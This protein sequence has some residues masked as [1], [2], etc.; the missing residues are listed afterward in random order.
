[1]NDLIL[2]MKNITKDFPG[3]R[4]LDDVSI[5]L[6]RSEVL[7]LLGE[8]GAG[9]S[10]LIKILSGVVSL[11]K[12]EILLNGNPVIFSNPG[13]S[14][15]QGIRV[16]Y[17]ELS[18]FES[19]TVVENIFAGEQI[20]KK[21]GFI[22]WNQMVKDANQVL[23]N[24]DSNID[25][26]EIMENLSVAAKQIVEIAKAVHKKAKIIVMDEPTSALNDKDVQTL[27]SIIKQLKRDGISIIYI[28]HRLEEIFAITDRVE[29]LRDGKNVGGGLINQIA[30]EDILK[31]IV[32]K[33]F[34]E[35]YPK[36]YVPKGD[37]I[38]EVNNISYINKLN[39]ISFKLR[40]GEIVA[41]FGLLG[42]GK[43]ELLNV[44]FGDLKKSSGDIIVNGKNVDINHPSIAKKN[45][46]GLVPIDRKDEGIALSLDVKS[47][48]VISNI[49][50]IGKGLRLSRAMR[51]KHAL[52]WIDR[53]NIKTPNDSAIVNTL[54][55]GNQQKIVL[56][57]WLEKG[58]NIL[59]LVE[60]TRG[61][62]IGSKAEIY[63]ILEDLCEQGAGVLMVS[64]ELPEVMAISDR[65]MV[66]KDGYIVN[67][68]QTSETSPAELMQIVT[69]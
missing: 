15:A 38:L 4:A 24:L 2:D 45:N 57:K 9:K 42:S 37:V 10:T 11:E 30:R 60:P 21:S 64:S 33:S 28:S 66:M 16:I 19:L 67:E 55:G 8:N 41:F 14:K 29:V 17:Q 12:G 3:V 47:N 44:I 53:L 26:L 54:S 5:N 35:L 13:E 34:S 52:Q 62:D 58:A 56:A 59:L 6:K 61:I 18:S 23:S 40:K 46:I 51:K 68:F 7:G 32:G 43:Q 31:M 48:I 49:E 20:L 25:P 27:Y 22:N 69:A 39:D 1:M 50:K 65:I 63:S 36:R